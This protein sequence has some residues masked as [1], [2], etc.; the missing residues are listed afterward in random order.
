MAANELVLIKPVVLVFLKTEIVLLE[1]FVTTKSGFPSPSMSPI[2]TPCGLEPVVKSTL[3][4]KE[5]VP[6]EPAVLV[7][8][9]NETVLLVMFV[10]AKSGLPS[11]SIS[12]IATFSGPVP[13][14]KSTLA[15]N[16]PAVIEPEVL[17]FLKTETVLLVKFVT[18]K[19]GLPSPSMSQKVTPSGAVPVV[20]STF[21]A[22]VV[23]SITCELGKVTIKGDLEYAVKLVVTFVTEIG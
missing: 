1:T 8:L 19:S 9:N 12:P 23:A 18:A 4:A 22:K 13:V 20:M 14:V 11:P 21:A 6:I 17:V 5:P 15:L 3:V 16:E 7:F 10:T 2:A